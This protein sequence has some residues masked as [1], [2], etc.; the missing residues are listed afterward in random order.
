MARLGD[1]FRASPIVVGHLCRATNH[2][3]SSSLTL[4][5]AGTFFLGH[6]DLPIP[7]SN[8]APGDAAA[9]NGPYPRP[10]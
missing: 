7:I 5:E 6:C 10:R 4:F 1:W 2:A 9:I 3:F 8:G